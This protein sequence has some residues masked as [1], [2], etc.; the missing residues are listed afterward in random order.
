MLT[1]GHHQ[2]ISQKAKKDHPFHGP[3]ERLDFTYIM[4]QPKDDPWAHLTIKCNLYI[5]LTGNVFA[6]HTCE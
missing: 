5:Q 1:D 3:S 4:V 2:S 6:E